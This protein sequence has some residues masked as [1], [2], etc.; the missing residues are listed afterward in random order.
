MSYTFVI[1]CDYMLLFVPHMLNPR[2]RSLCYGDENTNGKEN[3]EEMST[4]KILRSIEGMTDV[5]ME[6]VEGIVQGLKPDDN[7]PGL[8]ALLTAALRVIREGSNQNQNVATIKPESVSQPMSLPPH[9]SMSAQ[10]PMP[11]KSP[12]KSFNFGTDLPSFVFNEPITSLLD[13]PTPEFG[14]NPPSNESFDHVSVPWSEEESNALLEGVKKYGSGR[15]G[16]RE[17]LK[18]GLKD[19]LFHPRRTVHSLHA[20]YAKLKGTCRRFIIVLEETNEQLAEMVAQSHA[21]AAEQ[22]ICSGSEGNRLWK[23][24][25]NKVIKITEIPT[26]YT[27]K[28]QLDDLDKRFLVT[29]NYKHHVRALKN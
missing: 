21:V 9:V 29:A 18:N 2:K 24:Y 5:S 27:P 11:P 7:V 23:V 28:S 12:E 8:D 10:I 22:Y 16:I 17:I 20:R 3:A 19:G 6:C 1:D 25:E 15:I 4:E 14:F 26:Q 13:L